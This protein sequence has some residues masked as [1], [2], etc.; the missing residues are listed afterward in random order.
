MSS[1]VVI[2]AVLSLSSLQPEATPPYLSPFS[3]DMVY[4]ALSLDGQGLQPVLRPWEV[5]ACTPGSWGDNIGGG[6]AIGVPWGNM[7]QCSLQWYTES[8]SCLEGHFLRTEALQ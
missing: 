4:I 5:L 6:S 2:P 1:L 3:C 8:T 7:P